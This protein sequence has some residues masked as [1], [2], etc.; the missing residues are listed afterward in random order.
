MSVF[1]DTTLEIQERNIIQIYEEK[2]ETYRKRKQ[3]LCSQSAGM[4][5]CPAY[6][7][8]GGLSAAVTASKR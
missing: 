2:T 1:A 5:D 6:D 7:G 3:A 8:V 4:G